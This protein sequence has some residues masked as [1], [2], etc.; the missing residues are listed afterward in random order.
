MP[1][2]TKLTKH[3]E[4]LNTRQFQQAIKQVYQEA[5]AISI[6]YAISEKADNLVLIPGDFGWNDVGDW[7]VVYQLGEKNA[8]G[9]VILGEDAAVQTVTQKSYGNLIHGNHRLIALY[10]LKDFIVLIPKKFY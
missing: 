10:G 6:D 4:K 3:L 9:N 8:A 1:Q 7:R 5:E 2:L